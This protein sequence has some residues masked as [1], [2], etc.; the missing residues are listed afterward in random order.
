VS[1]IFVAHNFLIKNYEHNDIGARLVNTL[2]HQYFIKGGELGI[3]DVKEVS[4]Q[5]KLSLK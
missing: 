1:D 2:I 4:F 5:K 3:E